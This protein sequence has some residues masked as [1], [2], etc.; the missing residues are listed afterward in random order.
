MTSRFRLMTANLLNVRSDSTAFASLVARFDPDVVVVQELG[1]AAAEILE[2]RYPVHQLRPAHDFDGRGLASRLPGET[3]WIPMDGRDGVGAKLQ[4]DSATIRVAGIH[5]I[6]PLDFPWWSSKRRRGLQI[7][8]LFG[9]LSQDEGPAVVAGDF[10]ATPRWPA[11]KR[12]AARLDDLVLGQSDRPDP[13]WGY[14]P[15]WP[16]V[17]RIDHIFGAGVVATNVETA[18]V[19]G[20]DHVAV[21]ADLAVV[22]P[23]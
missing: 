15:G 19:D 9:W 12:V 16:K 18:A 13:T 5:L 8:G 4:L 21:V 20:S 10:N 6:N 3:F 22:D 1:P 11:Y 17:L 14:R 7:D 2:N 23:A